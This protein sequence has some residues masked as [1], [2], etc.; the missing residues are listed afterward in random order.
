[1]IIECYPVVSDHT[2]NM[3]LKEPLWHEFIFRVRSSD[4]Q[5]RWSATQWKLLKICSGYESRRRRTLTGPTDFTTSVNAAAVTCGSFNSLTRSAGQM[6]RFEIT[7][8]EIQKKRFM[9]TININIHIILYRRMTQGRFTSRLKINFY[10][11]LN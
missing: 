10:R 9:F 8:T 5:F 4:R 11:I 7:V 3:L 2:T 1:M 6:W